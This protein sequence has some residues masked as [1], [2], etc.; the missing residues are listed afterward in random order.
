ML[1]IFFYDKKKN[2]GDSVNKIFWERISNKKVRHYNKN[3][4]Y[5][6]TGSIMHFVNNKSIIFGTGFIS[7]NSDLGNSK[8]NTNTNKINKKPY[9]II[10]VRGPLT[11]NKL[12]ENKIDCPE[13]YGDPL[14]LMPCIY[15]KHSKID[16]KIVGIIPHYID[17]N[18]DNVNKLKQNLEDNGYIVK[19]IDIQIHNDY[20]TLINN[21]LE[22]KYIISSSLHGVIMGIIYNKK[23]CFLE[24]SDKVI[25]KQFK[26]YDF[27]KSIDINFEYKDFKNVEILNNYIKVD[28]KKLIDIGLNLIKLISFIDNKRK[29]YL[30]EIYKN[31][32]AEQNL[33]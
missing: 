29:T 16:E 32:Y 2:F 23:T 18:N 26:F 27:F 33:Y 17:K 31:F 13:E 25:G 10:S 21:I 15:N 24:F 14:I 20:K 9:K 11:R 8:C 12:I 6:T 22:C 3:I 19:I 5:I 1:N 4:H 28:Y 30:S 7:E